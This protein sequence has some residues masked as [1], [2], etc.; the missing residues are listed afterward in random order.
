MER[1]RVLRAGFWASLYANAPTGSRWACA[2]T[3]PT[4]G[5][6]YIPP[7]RVLRR[8]FSRPRVS[9]EARPNRRLT[10]VFSS[11]SDVVYFRNTG[12]SFSDPSRLVLIDIRRTHDKRMW[13]LQGQH[14]HT[15]DSIKSDLAQWAK[16]YPPPP[17]AQLPN[18]PGW[19][20]ILI[21]IFSHINWLQARML[22]PT[23]PRRRP[24]Y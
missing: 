24:I 6:S 8:V 16:E 10:L 2:G 21:R 9:H 12:M 4:T 3:V 18:N 23:P 7:P 20:V 11:R 1:I 17:G 14:S 15:L 22:S 19:Y 13:I 5:G